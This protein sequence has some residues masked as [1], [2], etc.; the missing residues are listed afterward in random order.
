MAVRPRRDEAGI[1]AACGAA[2]AQGA[3]RRPRRCRR[4]SRVQSARMGSYRWPPT[5]ARVS[6]ARTS[7][8]T[9]PPGQSPADPAARTCQPSPSYRQPAGREPGRLEPKVT[10]CPP[11][12]PDKPRTARTTTLPTRPVLV[13]PA[14]A[15]RRPR[16]WPAGAELGNLSAR[17]LPRLTVHLAHRVG[18]RCGMTSGG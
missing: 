15:S 8:L 7:D 3:R 11:S 13:K 2:Q 12:R 10:S 1:L 6:I 17:V 4:A 9:G 14:L 18:V 5:L 16:T